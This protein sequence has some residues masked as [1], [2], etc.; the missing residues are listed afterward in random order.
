MMKVEE[1]IKEAMKSLGFTDY[2]VII[3]LTLLRDGEMDARVLSEK[4]KVPYSRIYE[5]LN[6]MIKKGILMKIDGR[7][8]TYVANPP[9]EMLKNLKQRMNQDF[10]ENSEVVNDYLTQLY[11]PEKTNVE[12][13]LTLYF[14]EK[15]NLRRFKNV[16]KNTSRNL[17]LVMEEFEKFIPQIQDELNY[18]KVTSVQI[19][20]ILP[21]NVKSNAFLSDLETYAEIKHVKGPLAG[22]F[23]MSDNEMVHCFHRGNFGFLKANESEYLGMS[24]NHPGLHA[25][26]YHLIKNNL[27]KK[28]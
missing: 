17:I 8:S 19:Q 9:Q 5:V 22:Q 13:P 20:V 18:L 26:I 3:L 24:G 23:A 2:N 28:T 10:Q 21:E 16:V 11:S 25:M 6:D 1:N 15:A 12:I 7:P 27:E 14:G 4:T